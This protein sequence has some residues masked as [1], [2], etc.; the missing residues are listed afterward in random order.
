MQG[1]QRPLSFLQRRLASRSTHTLTHEGGGCPERR[2][3]SLRINTRTDASGRGRF[4]APYSPPSAETV[5]GGGEGLT[6]TRMWGGQISAYKLCPHVAQLSRSACP[7]TP[8]LFFCQ[9]SG[10]KKL[11]FARQTSSKR[12]KQTFAGIL[13]Q[14]GCHLPQFPEE[15]GGGP[16]NFT[17]SFARVILEF[18][19]IN[20]DFS[21]SKCS[22]NFPGGYNNDVGVVSAKSVHSRSVHSRYNVHPER[23][24]RSY[25][26]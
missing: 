24:L 5:V 6:L 8:P 23:Y 22:R 17:D 13:P 9:Q 1:Q 7:Q 18:S 11:L 19:W 10:H 20:K 25:L 4:P 15:K 14:N 3:A 16:H 2:Q 26:C 12:P 21:R